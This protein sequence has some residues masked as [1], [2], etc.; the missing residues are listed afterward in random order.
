[1]RR[2]VLTAVVA[3]AGCGGADT[4][5]GPPPSAPARMHLQSPALRSGASIPTRFTCEGKNVSPPLRWSAPP[6]RT[7]SLALL[8]EDPDAPGG[9]FVHWVVVG[10]P[11]SSRSLPEGRIPP[12][13]KATKQS[14]G[15]EGYGGPCP[16]EGDSPHHYVLSLY[17]LD[18]PLALGSGSSPDGAR[19]AIRKAA[20]ARGTL[21]ATYGR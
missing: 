12:P 9:T 4:V 14:S 20:I 2:L 10:L 16:P 21:A 17:A 3:L 15:K 13:A 6:G 19:D 5:K 8:M 18:R 7:R 11:A 1:V